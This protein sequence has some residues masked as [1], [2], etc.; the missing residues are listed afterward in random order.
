MSSVLICVD[1]GCKQEY[2]QLED[3][4][5]QVV[6]TAW[7][8]MALVAAGYHRRDR[9]PLAAAALALLRA[10]ARPRVNQS[11]LRDA[12]H[13]VTRG[14]TWGTEDVDYRVTAALSNADHGYLCELGHFE[15]T[16]M[17]Y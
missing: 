7:A 3:G 10:Q 11:P 16:Q 1:V 5:S 6:N 9:A 8:L 12:F 4:S 13:C 17:L 14:R 2:S 15:I